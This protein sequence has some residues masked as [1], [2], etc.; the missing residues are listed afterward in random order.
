M[1]V[2]AAFRSA[3]DCAAAVIFAGAMLLSGALTTGASAQSV[4]DKLNSWL[5]GT[6]PSTNS[7]PAEANTPAEIDC[8]GVEVRQGA[9]TLAVSAP[10]TDAGPMTTRYQVGIS[11][12][13]RECAPLGSV[14]TMK[15]GV[16]GRVLLG[17][18]GTPGQLDIPLRM[19]VVQEGANP[20]TIVSKFYRLAVAIPP[21]QTSVPFVHVEQ[22]LTF[23]MPRGADLD[24]YVV[25][26]GFDPSAAPAKP[27]R[28]PAK[29]QKRQ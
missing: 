19:A 26:V 22:D 12:T 3:Q 16:Q 2:S 23:P 18:A 1:N 13:A 11:Q 6:P 14:M 4:S 15:V 27:E 25:Y 7:A 17:P 10:G 24:S 21:G 29:K 5:F 28:K 9:S 20:K 8:P